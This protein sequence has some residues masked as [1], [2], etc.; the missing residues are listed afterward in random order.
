[1]R[2]IVPENIK[3]DIPNVEYYGTEILN[4]ETVDV[5]VGNIGVFN[6]YRDQLENVKYIQLLS[7]GY[8]SLELKGLE[9]KVVC[10]AR[11]AYSGPIAEYT[12]AYLLSIYRQHDAFKQSQKDHRW[13]RD[14]PVTTLYGKQVAYLG[15]GDIAFETQ[16]RLKPFGVSSI[17]VNSNGRE[18]PGF[19]AFFALNDLQ[20]ALSDADIVICSLPLNPHT[21]GLLGSEQFAMMKEGSIFVNVGRGPV[22]KSKDLLEAL[23]ENVAY[24]IL[25][26]FEKEPVPMDD[27]IWDHPRVIMTP[28]VSGDAQESVIKLQNLLT[29][30]ILLF[31]NGETPKNQ[32]N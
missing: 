19:D 16:S 3:L 26:V 22:V 2:I 27:P 30:N 20:Q 17:A 9:N 7:A 18:V 8:D 25:D 12:V 4:P 5:F 14:I 10:N 24:A 29:Q 15:A 13:N 32:I 21:D 11:G 28:H 6:A 1:M 31:Q 23:E